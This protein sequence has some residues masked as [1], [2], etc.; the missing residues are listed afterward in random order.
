MLAPVFR[1]HALHRGAGAAGKWKAKNFTP[2]TY[3][4]Q[5]KQ[6]VSIKKRDTRNFNHNDFQNDLLN[7]TFI[8]ALENTDNTNMAFNMYNKKFIQTLNIHAPM[9]FLSKKEIKLKLL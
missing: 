1:A 9:K 5:N 8:Q 4:V 3:H 6:Q 7:P 2:F